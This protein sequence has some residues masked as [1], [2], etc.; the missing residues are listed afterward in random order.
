MQLYLAYVGLPAA[1]DA[2]ECVV[3]VSDVVL[4]WSVELACYSVLI[5]GVKLLYVQSGC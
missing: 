1:Q 2:A 3:T 5:C 4:P